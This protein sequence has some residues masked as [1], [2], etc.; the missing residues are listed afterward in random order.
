MKPHHTNPFGKMVWFFI[1]T[2]FCFVAC[3]NKTVI[4]VNPEFAKYINSYTS[5]VVS[6]KASIKIELATDAAVT[7]TLNEALTE[8]LFSFSPSVKG[9][10]FWVDAKTI[11]FKPDEDLQID[12]LYTVSFNLGKVVNVPKKFKEFQFNIQ[13]IKPSIEVQENGLRA[14][15]KELMSLTGSITTAD[16][17][18]SKQIEKILSA[19]FKGSSL[20]IKWQHNETAKTYSFTIDSITRSNN[21]QTLILSWDA[22]IIKSSQKDKAEI[23]VPALGE[24]KVLSVKAMQE[25]EQY[26]LVQFSDLL[27]IGQVLDGLITISN[28]ATPSYTI[29]GSEVKV[30]GSSKLEGN[31]TVNVNTGVQNMW[32]EKL[33]SNFTAN[34]FF[35]NR[36]PNVSIFG[37]GVILPNSSGKLLLPFDATNLKAVDVSI[38]KIYESNVPQFFQ[39]NQMNGSNNLRSVAKPIVQATLKL[40]T[41]KSLNLHKKNRFFLD[42]DKYL[43][44]E[45]GAMYHVV[46]GFRPQYSLYSCSEAVST[47]ANNEEEDYY[48][49][50]DVSDEDDVFWSRYN[51]YYPFGYDWEGRENPCSKAFYTRDKFAFRNILATNIGLTA[52]RGVNNSLL[53]AANNILTTEPM[54]GVSIEA[55][56]YQQQII[57][58]ASSNKDG[59]ALLET[60]RKPFLIVAKKGNEKSYL[61]VDDGN[62]LPLSRFSVDG[63][64][65]KNG[66]KGFVFG[67]RGVWRP[68]DSLFLSCIIEDK[69]KKL[70]VGHPLEM[71]LINP[72]GQLC[73]RIVQP[74]A[75]NGFNVFKTATDAN[76]PTGNWLCKIKCGGAIFD[77]QIKI[78]TVIPNRLKISVNF[79]GATALGKEVNKEATLNANWLFGAVAQNLKARIDAQLYNKETSFDN[80]KGYIFESPINKFSP[81][82]KT[83]FDGVLSAT[84][85]ANFNTNF[86]AGENAPGM[87]LANLMV[88]VFEPGGNF[89]IDNV[90]MPYHPYASYT[91]IKMPVQ[92]EG[93]GYIQPNKTYQI[94]VAE[95][96]NNG[97]ACTVTSDME[98]ELYKVQWR[99][100][101][102]RSEE[103]FSNFTQDEYNKLIKK[104]TFSFSNKIN[105]NLKVNSGDYGRYLILFKNKRTGHTT[106]SSFY[107]SDD[108]WRYNDESNNAGAVSMLSFTSNKNKYNVGE[109][110]KLTIPSSANGKMLVSIESG[111]KVLKTMWVTTKDKETNYSFTIE[112]GMAPN[113]YVNITMLQPHAQTVNDLPIRM[114]GVIPI[115]V[116]DKNTILHPTIKINNVLLPE[117]TSSITVA[118]QDGKKMDYVIAIVDE[119]LLDLTRFKT[120]NPHAA[121]YAKEALGVKT[122]DVY[123]YVIGAWGGQL[124]RILTIGGDGEAETAA[125]TRKANRFKPIVKFLGPFSSNGGS[126]THQFV[127]PN[128]MGSVR[129]MVIAT[130]NGA[131]GVAEKAVPVKKP[132]MLLATMPRVLGPAEEIKIPITVFATEN[133]IKNVS[134]SVQANNMLEIVSNNN[135]LS[136]SNTGEQMAYVTAKVKNTIGIGKLKVIAKSGRYTS[137]QEI[138]IE[139]RNPNQTITQTQEFTLPAGQSVNTNINMLGDANSSNAVVE[140]SSIPSI[141]LQKRLQYLI[142]YPHGCVEQTTSA[143]FPQLTLN[144][145][146]ELSEKQ[147]ADV[148]RNLR[149]GIQRLQNF[150]TSDGGFAYWPG[151]SKADEWGTNY[152]GHFLLEAQALGYN[153]SSSVLQNWKLYQRNKA[154]AWNVTAAPWY[155]TDL[156]QAYR[157][158]LLALAKAPEQGAM[159][160]LKEFKFLSAEAKWRLASAYYLVG[161]TS[162]ANQLIS[163]IPTTFTQR[164]YAGISFGSNVRDESMVL[165]SLIL[166]NRKAEANQLVRKI[167]VNLSSD[168]WYSTQTTAYSLLAISKFCGVNKD[169]KIQISGFAGTNKLN[170][171]S[172]STINQQQIAWQNNG[173]SVKL[174]NN[175]KNTL[176]VRVI[177]Q[178]KPVGIQPVT[179]TNNPAVLGINVSFLNTQG[180][181][182]DISKLKQGTDFL[183]KVTI[184]NPGKRG[185]YTQMALSQIF[186]SGWEILNT[187]MYNSEGAFQSSP[188]DYMD[189][190]DDRVYHYF[191]LNPNQTLT[192][193][194][195]LNAAYLGKFYWSGVY[196]EA[197]YDKTISAGVGGKLVE[198]E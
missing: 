67:E 105:Y 195:Q 177:N 72:R 10:A 84:G 11:E 19:N 76:A 165:E 51:N 15:N 123:D 145:I 140:V 172:T 153:V 38:V 121:F 112:K 175:G 181:A 160:R 154:N 142:E 69:E 18:D 111:T 170:V 102:D 163:G 133:T 167:A 92:N 198:V 34:I 190:K 178:G 109:D 169:S 81:Q 173:A 113:I 94:N 16:I 138:E 37:Q 36:L 194:V 57:G 28:Q 13:T 146:L 73:K 70:P 71:E 132:L 24:F 129:A 47:S 110:C 98:V 45:Q 60:K 156:V 88:K 135:N 90:S 104:E 8:N 95:V 42:I 68:G 41:D 183:A 58:K 89:S 143:I 83:V 116:E 144:S 96:N 14:I 27:M 125:K 149:V 162:V 64:D 61:R 66:I 100:W 197:M 131:Y 17:E 134:L 161:Q 176:F 74:N 50:E 101:W 150:V 186:P 4:S 85:S 55:L 87:L 120:P 127:L 65:V 26:V 126:K 189:I 141:N 114:Y 157:L 23:A 158:Y 1:A 159:N 43:K 117:E 20:P 44:T 32:G 152:A 187:R 78:E 7:H 180:A 9:K 192:Y 168:S 171:N 39:Q 12:K 6:K 166:M 46:I 97:T 108:D 119:G 122:W 31:F 29:L 174:T 53:V 164:P 54:S 30:Y 136:F 80:Y 48:D 33:S 86:N 130:S 77:K 179:Y 151:E 106:G 25:D 107:V 40:D 191:N 155:G 118:E 103:T 62:S 128:Y 22:N 182:V 99:W 193:Y 75:A 21:S 115:E 63:A 184:T 35:E 56:D 59:I 147:K 49:R 124:Q 185:A 91:G 196:A 79:N 188:A 3:K 5:G 137:Y 52:K 82:S 2:S 93:W 139:V 148:E